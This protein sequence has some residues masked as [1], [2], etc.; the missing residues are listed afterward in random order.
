LDVPPPAIL[1]NLTTAKANIFVPTLWSTRYKIPL[2]SFRL[3]K[4]QAERF[5]YGMRPI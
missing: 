1:A 3:P 2:F 5:H 4:K